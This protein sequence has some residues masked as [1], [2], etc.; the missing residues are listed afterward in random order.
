MKAD[1]PAIDGDGACVRGKGAAENFHQRALAGT[2]FAEKSQHLA[3]LQGQINAAQCLHAG[4]GTHDAA[5]LKKWGSHRPSA[6]SRATRIT[7][8][9][10]STPVQKRAAMMP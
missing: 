9:S 5:H 2:V 8:A 4:K 1:F 3:A 6:F 7:L 10:R